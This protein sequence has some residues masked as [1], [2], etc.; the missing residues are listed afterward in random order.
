MH[1]EQEAQTMQTSVKTDLV[2]IRMNSKI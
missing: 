1:E 2:R